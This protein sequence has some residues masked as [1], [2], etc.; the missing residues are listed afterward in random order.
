MVIFNTDVFT[1]SSF[2][3]IDLKPMHAIII[4]TITQCI[5]NRIANSFSLQDITYYNLS[6]V[7]LKQNS[8][9]LADMSTRHIRK[10]LYDLEE[11]GLIKQYGNNKQCKKSY[12]KIHKTLLKLGTI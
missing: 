9:F 12:F 4:S 7:M 5:N 6:P 1:K 2:A 3:K 10:L 11:F 8:I